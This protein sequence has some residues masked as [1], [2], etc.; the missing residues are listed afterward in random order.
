MIVAELLC[1]RKEHR[2]PQAWAKLPLTPTSRSCLPT[3]PGLHGGDVIDSH[4]RRP[5][6]SI[7]IAHRCCSVISAMLRPWEVISREAGRPRAS[8]LQA[9]TRRRAGVAILSLHFNQQEA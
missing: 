2:P 7:T 9:G 1:I 3:G 5:L 6:T 4:G 8:R